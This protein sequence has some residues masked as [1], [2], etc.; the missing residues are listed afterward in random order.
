MNILD[1]IRFDEQFG[2]SQLFLAGLRFADRAVHAII[3]QP[4]FQRLTGNKLAHRDKK[5][6]FQ[7]HSEATRQIKGWMVR[8]QVDKRREYSLFINSDRAPQ[9]LFDQAVIGFT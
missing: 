8:I 6:C 1:H 7:Q 4:T 9:Y 5:S 2:T 3:H